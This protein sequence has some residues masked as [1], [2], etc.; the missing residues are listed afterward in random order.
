MQFLC[1][2][3]QHAAKR[4]RTLCREPHRF[5]ARRS[6]KIPLHTPKAHHISAKKAPPWCNASSNSTHQ[7]RAQRHAKGLEAF[8]QSRVGPRHGRILAFDAQLNVAA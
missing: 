1:H 8:E 7:F 3:H 4:N 2:R 6:K 5:Q